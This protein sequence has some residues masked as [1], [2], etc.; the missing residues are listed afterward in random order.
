MAILG[1]FVRRYRVKSVRNKNVFLAHFAANNTAKSRKNRN[2]SEYILK[3]HKKLNFL[4][5]VNESK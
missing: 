1:R 2:K 5:K 4:K 3:L